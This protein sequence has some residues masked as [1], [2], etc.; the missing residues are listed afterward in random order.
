MKYLL[1][2]LSNNIKTV[3]VPVNNKQVVSINYKIK[4]GFY[5]EYKGINN[6]THLLEHLIATFFN[7]EQCSIDSLKKHIGTKVLKTNAYTAD[8]EVCFWI[9]CYYRDIEFFIDLLSRSLF[10]LCI[11]QKNLDMSKKNVIKELQQSENEYFS[12]D[13]N[14]FLFKRKKV[15]F[16]YGIQ[17]VNNATCESVERF[18]KLIFA[19]DIIIG[20]TC[21]K[22]YVKSIYNLLKTKFD[23]KFEKPEKDMLPINFTLHYPKKTKIY[24]HYKPIK[25]VEINIVIPIDIDKRTIQYYNLMIGLE[26]LFSFDHGE[27]YKVLRHEMKLIYGI[28]YEI[29]TDD[30]DSKKSY[31]NVHLKCQPP[32]LQIVLTIFNNIFS[33]FT[34]SKEMFKMTKNKLYFS[35]LYNYMNDYDDFQNYYVDCIFFSKPIINIPDRIKNVKYKDTCTMISKLKKLNRLVFLY[36]QKYKKP[37]I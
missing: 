37:K 5:N 24:R 16:E 22:R 26:Y 32:D 7:S 11:T 28:G 19:K 20:V 23:V 31:V 27:M 34:I 10:D 36:N 18:Y 4:C 14:T 1:T 25:S 2:T 33:K 9:E 17:D 15:S 21:D 12:N 29:I 13:I 6:Y 35:T 3:I 8:N 30:I